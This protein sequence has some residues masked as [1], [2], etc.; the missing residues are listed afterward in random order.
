MVGL[1]CLYVHGRFSYTFDRYLFIFVSIPL[2]DTLSMASSKAKVPRKSALPFPPPFHRPQ[3]KK[4]LARSPQPTDAKT[5]LNNTASPAKV[6]T[7]ATPFDI[8]PLTTL[9]YTQPKNTRQRPGTIGTAQDK[10]EQ[11]HSKRR[12][13]LR[14][15]HDRTPH[16]QAPVKGARLS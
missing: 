1:L 4:P 5:S 13:S 16:Q 3:A 12:R 15:T 14:Q 9:L 7:R 6:W 2:I 8:H 10:V 11:S